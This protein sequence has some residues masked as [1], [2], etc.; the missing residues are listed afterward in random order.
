MLIAMSAA[1]LYRP[2]CAVTVSNTATGKTQYYITELGS[3]K[4]ERACEVCVMLQ[5]NELTQTV[6]KRESFRTDSNRRDFTLN[7]TQSQAYNTTLKN[8][9]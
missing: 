3:R 7:R 6:N 4:L 8:K 9:A 2:S 1:A 5:S